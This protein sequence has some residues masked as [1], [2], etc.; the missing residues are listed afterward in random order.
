MLLR[1]DGTAATAADLVVG[2]ELTLWI[3]GPIAE[4]YPVQ[5]QAQRI[6]LK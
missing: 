2:R 3:T 1:A 5:V 4:S 6:I